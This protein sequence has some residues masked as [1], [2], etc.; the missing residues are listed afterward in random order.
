[1]SSSVGSDMYSPIRGA[2]SVARTNELPQRISPSP[3]E[4]SVERRHVG[5]PRT[6]PLLI[7]IQIHGT[8]DPKRTEGKYCFAGDNNAFSQ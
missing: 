7:I 8:L 2:M 3:V 4:M 6:F 1:M 5:K